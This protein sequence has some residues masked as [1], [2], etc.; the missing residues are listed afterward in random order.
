MAHRSFPLAVSALLL[1]VAFA[2]PIALG[3]DKRPTGPTTLPPPPSRPPPSRPQQPQSHP[4]R[5]EHR[6]RREPPYCPP[7]AAYVPVKPDISFEIRLL[8]LDAGQ[9]DVPAV[10]AFL[11]ATSN[12][13][14]QRAGLQARAKP[15]GPV[16]QTS[17]GQTLNVKQDATGLRDL[18]ASALRVSAHPHLDARGAEAV[19]FI[20]EQ[21]PA[22]KPPLRTNAYVS[23]VFDNGD[24]KLLSDTARP[25]GTR[26]LV[27]ATVFF[28]PCSSH[29]VPPVSVLSVW[30]SLH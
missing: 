23:L 8:S 11:A 20:V 24:T 28:P 26:R 10:S 5:H 18:G 16:L 14:E 22:G 9:A 12:P 15:G 27:Y 29:P 4:D 25:D 2:P 6:E 19:D 1:G 3:L 7:P 30:Q 17:G 21:T 13:D